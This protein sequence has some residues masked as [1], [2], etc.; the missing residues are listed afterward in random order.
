MLFLILF[1]ICNII[2]LPLIAGEYSFDSADEL[3]RF[4][5]ENGYTI[6]AI[7]AGKDLNIKEFPDDFGSIYS[8]QRKKKLFK[9]IILPLALK[10]NRRIAT[11]RHWLQVIRRRWRENGSLNELEETFLNKLLVSYRLYKS[12]ELPETVDDDIFQRL[13][14]RV[15]IVPTSLVLAQAA[16]ESGWGTSRFV[17][18]A[19]NIFGQWTFNKSMGLKPAGVD[20]SARHRVRIFPSLQASVRSYMRNLNTH[21]A[22][23]KFRRLR[24]KGSPDGIDSLEL[25]KGLESY[26][27]RGQDYV[28]DIAGMIKHNNYREFD[29]L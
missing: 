25:V 23:R 9:K 4:L 21:R 22:Y 8:V 16:N 3:E 14:S 13:L 1:L 18:K 17:L 15:N 12:D 26:S 27:Q 24:A 20:D 5:N 19:N 2:S 28:Q 7:L 11:C 29:E 6:S 10:E